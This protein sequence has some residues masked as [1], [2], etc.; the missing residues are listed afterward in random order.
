VLGDE[1]SCQFLNLAGRFPDDLDVADDGVLVP[2]IL[3]EGSEIIDVMKV[4][5]GACNGSAICSK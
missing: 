4:A 5:R 2:L 1:V 3:F